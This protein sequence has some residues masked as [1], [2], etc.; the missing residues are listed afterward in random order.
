MPGT[1]VFVGT[2]ASL[3]A[4]LTTLGTASPGGV[5]IDLTGNI[6]LTAD[7]P[8]VAPAAGVS[9]LV[10]GAT[11]TIDGGGLHHGFVV[12]D[13]SVDI[14]D[15]TLAHMTAQ[16]AA[17]AAGGGGGGL[18]AGGAL[19][20]EAGATVGLG[21]VGFL[22]NSAIGGA[23]G[24]GAAAASGRA[25]AAG[26]VG[27]PGPLGASGGTLGAGGTVGGG[28]GTAGGPGQPGGLGGGFGAG[29]GGGGSGAPGNHGSFG[30]HT[31]GP[32]GKG[33]GGGAG[34]AGGFGGGGGG[35]GGG[36]YGGQGG[37]TLFPPYIYGANGAPGAGGAGGASGYGAGL[38]AVGVA[39]SYPSNGGGGGGGGGLGAGGAVF[40]QQGG[41]VL[42]GAGSVSG[43]VVQGGSVGAGGTAGAALGVGL[44]IQGDNTVTFDPAAGQTLTLS[45]PI[46]DQNG[47]GGAGAVLVTGGG[48]VALAAASTFTGGTTITG[49]AVLALQTGTPGAG[50]ISFAGAGTLVVPVSHPI[51]NTILGFAAGDTFDVAGITGGG[52]LY[53]SGANRLIVA[54]GG[55]SET[56]QLGGHLYQ[57]SGFSVAAVGSHT[58]VTY[59]A[60]FA[61]GTRI[62]TPAGERPVECL[63][64]G[65]RVVSHFGGSAPVVWVGHRTLDPRRHPRPHEVQ[66]VRVRAGAFAERVPARDLL[67]SP[68][69]AVYVNEV[70][71]PIRHLLNGATVF[72]E[73]RDAVSYF[74]VELPT[75][76]VVLADG[77]PA[78]SYLDTGNRC[79]FANGGGAVLM[80]PDFALSVWQTE[81]CAPLVVAGEK[82]AAAKARLL[83]RAGQLRHA[84][85]ADPELRLLVDGHAAAARVVDGTHRFAL[86]PGA[87]TGRLQSRTFTPAHMLAPSA[88]HRRLGA[89][90]AALALDGRA[91]DLASLGAGW[92]A[93]EPGLRWT[94]GSGAIALDGARELAVRL[95][96]TGRY[97]Q[98]PREMIRGVA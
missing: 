49:G 98:A 29:G 54:G 94:D 46:A 51:G 45:D 92:H 69:H 44:F 68:D 26:G 35:G 58:L 47:N 80:H 78:E 96:L 34:G 6:T 32:G 93:P 22:G 64:A 76:D 31:G 12:A 3:D 55:L 88:D 36:G 66:P 77:L 9:L 89:A 40:I 82:L 65:D 81:A 24:A 13:G 23:G 60:C 75:H 2:E 5:T 95:A 53:D 25:S 90:V 97:W 91:L 41:A 86:P 7:L 50:S 84:V 38:G 63:R 14:Q 52:T 87:L 83:A 28:F 72:Q 70:L 10:S 20:V 42:F 18:G 74:H 37:G 15:L 17:G 16:G 27:G 8:I 21:G 43:G 19:F 71:I 61:A 56:L 62:A 33:G 1:T 85:T 79:A 67:L 30:T 73:E 4:A 59:V 57:A 11:F 39:G 48:T